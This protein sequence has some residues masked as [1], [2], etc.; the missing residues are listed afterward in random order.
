MSAP[1]A[2]PQVGAPDPEKRTSPILEETDEDIDVAGALL[3][4]DGVCYFNGH[5]FANGAY[6]RSGTELLV[7]RRGAWVRVG[8][9]DPH[10][11]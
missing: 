1:I 10:N 5:A 9:G 11:P 3:T 4:E 8:S 2:A 6:V 7:C